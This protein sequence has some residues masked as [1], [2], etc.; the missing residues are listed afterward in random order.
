MS[1]QAP[2]ATPR[3]HAPATCLDPLRPRL[4]AVRFGV[5]ALATAGALSIAAV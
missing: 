4:A 1:A 3:P 5:V 2:F